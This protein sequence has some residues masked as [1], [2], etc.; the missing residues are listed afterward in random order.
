MKVCLKCNTVNSDQAKTCINCGA[1]LPIPMLA[2]VCPHCGKVCARDSDQCPACHYDLS[3]IKPQTIMPT[4]EAPHHNR[5]LLTVIAVMACIVGIIFFVYLGIHYPYQQLHYDYVGIKVRYYDQHHHYCG[6]N[7]YLVKRTKNDRLKKV[8]NLG[9]SDQALQKLTTYD[10][11]GMRRLYREAPRVDNLTFG[12]KLVID[13]QPRIVVPLNN[14]HSEFYYD[15]R[16]PI[17][18]PNHYVPGR[19]SNQP[20]V[21]YLWFTQVNGK[22][23]Q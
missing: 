3:G 23:D 8:V 7:L 18:V 21:R 15:H 4:V 14:K 1:K 11:N 20:K 6:R 22:I 12:K 10:I 16:D 5:R 2:I 9:S 13:G 17:E 19:V